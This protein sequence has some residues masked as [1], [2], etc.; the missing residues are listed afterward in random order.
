VLPTRGA[1]HG[2]DVRRDAVRA[3]MRRAAPIAQAGSAL[4]LEAGEPLVAGLAADLVS[5]T[6]LRHRIEVHPVIVDEALALV[7]G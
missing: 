7:H 6:Q 2:R 3:L 4:L 5:R 1:D